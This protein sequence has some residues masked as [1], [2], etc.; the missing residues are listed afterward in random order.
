MKPKITCDTS[1]YLKAANEVEELLSPDLLDLFRDSVMSCFGSGTSLSESCDVDYRPA[2]KG[3]G[4]LI[5]TFK[6]SGRLLALLTAL[7]TFKVHS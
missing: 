6:P 5:A 7:R 4:D 3:T 2:P 1:P